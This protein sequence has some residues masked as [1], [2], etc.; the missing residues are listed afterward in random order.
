MTTTIEKIDIVTGVGYGDEGKGLTTNFLVRQRQKEGWNPLVVRYGGGNQVGHTV[1]VGDNIFEHHHT[2]SGSM[3][4]VSTFYSKNC[5]VDP[6]GTVKEL[7]ELHEMGF[8]F[9]NIYHAN[10]MIVTPMDVMF[11]QSVEKFNNHGSVGVGFGA[12]I[13]RNEKHHRLYVQDIRNKD[14]FIQ[15]FKEA[16]YHYTEDEDYDWNNGELDWTGDNIAEQFY[17]E[18]VEFL[19][20]VYV[21]RNLAEYLDV[22]SK[23]VDALVFEGHQGTLLD[24]EYGIFPNVTRSKTTCKNAFEIIQ[25]NGIFVAYINNHMVTRCYHTRH[26]NGF[27]KEGHIELINDQWETNSFNEHQ[28]EFKK[29][30]LNISLLKSG[31]DYNLTD[32]PPIFEPMTDHNLVITCC[33]Q[34]ADSDKIV[35]SLTYVLNDKIERFYTNA[36][37]EGNLEEVYNKEIYA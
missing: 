36:S 19:A 10:C 26:G 34:V 6:I 14:L 31:I 8:T 5:T 2:G 22:H 13:D 4:N 20:R 30:P 29:A 9:D 17:D 12:T 1:K 27:F 25:E 33:D 24:M 11:N 7:D 23:S 35:Q 15:K 32:V 28:G 37:P 21:F 18:C 3:S 16:V